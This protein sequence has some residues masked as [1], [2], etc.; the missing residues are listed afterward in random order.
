MHINDG[1]ASSTFLQPPPASEFT[2]CLSVSERRL[3]LL[4][5]WNVVWRYVPKKTPRWS[6]FQGRLRL[7]HGIVLIIRYSMTLDFCVIPL[8]DIC[9]PRRYPEGRGTSE[10]TERHF[11]YVTRHFKGRS[12]TDAYLADAY[13]PRESSLRVIESSLDNL[14]ES[15]CVIIAYFRSK[16]TKYEMRN[17][18]MNKMGTTP[19]DYIY[20]HLPPIAVFRKATTLLFGVSLAFAVSSLSTATRPDR[21]DRV[22]AIGRTTSPAAAAAAATADG[23]DDA[24]DD[25]ADGVDVRAG[26]S[27]RRVVPHY[28]SRKSFRGR[29][30]YGG[31]ELVRLSEGRQVDNALCRTARD[32]PAATPAVP[33]VSH[34][35]PFSSVTPGNTHS[36]AAAEFAYYKMRTPL[37][38]REA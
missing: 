7:G 2:T 5:A 36:A 16:N 3:F 30:N 28:R 25:D 19:S 33:L 37:I 20:S 8:P 13:Y 18:G 38:P 27:G 35:C 23:G 21:Q 9:I 11:R 10:A 6:R 32:R 24:D 12:E 29:T 34:C 22:A 1:C 17:Y 4:P 15:S 26:G 14:D 31:E